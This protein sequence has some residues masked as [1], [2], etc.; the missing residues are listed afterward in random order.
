MS[1]F[2][3]RPICEHLWMRISISHT[4]P[5][6]AEF[7]PRHFKGLLPYEMEAISDGDARRVQWLRSGQTHLV[8]RCEKCGDCKSETLAGIHH[9]TLEVRL[10]VRR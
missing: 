9:L 5:V 3:R 4:E 7:F 6:D 1:L 2:R 8:L 10:A